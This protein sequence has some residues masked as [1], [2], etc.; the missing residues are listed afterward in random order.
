MENAGLG[1]DPGFLF[2]EGANIRF[3]QKFSQKA[4][5]TGNIGWIHQCWLQ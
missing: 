1:A 2:E 5:E 4:Q 3:M